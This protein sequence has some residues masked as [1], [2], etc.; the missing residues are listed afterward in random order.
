MSYTKIA[1]I[2]A[3]SEALSGQ[4]VSVGGWVR[5]IRDL[6]GFGFIELND[7]SCFRNLQVVM[8]AEALSNYKDIAAQNVGAALI[9][10]GV[11]TLTPDATNDKLTIAAKDTT[12]AAATQSVAGLMSAADKKKLD[13]VATGANKYSL[14]TATAS[15][16]GGVTYVLSSA[17]VSSK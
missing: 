13:G 17:S 10:T 6:K 14:P 5:T 1:K 7:G 15:V 4:T 12:Y 11:V 3:D 9:V 16:L 2:F 8:E